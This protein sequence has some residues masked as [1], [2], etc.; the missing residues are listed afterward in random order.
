M[1]HIICHAPSSKLPELS[2]SEE[3]YLE[4]IYTLGG[5]RNG[6]VKVKQLAKNLKI[7]DPSV[8]GMLRKL[9]EQGF[10]KYDRSGVKLTSKG[11]KHAVQVVR[12]HQLAERLLADVFDYRLPKVHDMACKFEHVL[13]NELT[14]RIEKMLGNPVTCPHGNPIPTSEGTLKKIES[15]QLTETPKG[16][17]CLVLKIP[18]DRGAVERL[19]ALNVIPGVKVKVLEKLPRGAIILLCGNT[20]VALSRNIASQI[21]VRGRHRHRHR[22]SS[23]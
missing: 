13:D 20:Q 17:E 21:Q 4:A 12:R 16:K 8:V 14:D 18:E 19:L 2:P 9:K 1:A 5:Q 22:G 11:K 7:K 15:A 3:E 6:R 23:K 10:V